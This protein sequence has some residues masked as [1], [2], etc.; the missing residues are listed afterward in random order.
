LSV[1]FHKS[2]S[3]VLDSSGKLVCSISRIGNVFQADFFFCSIFFE[4]L[5]FIVFF[6]ALEMA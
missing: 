2:D 5:D 1:F 3:Y 6:R 4:V